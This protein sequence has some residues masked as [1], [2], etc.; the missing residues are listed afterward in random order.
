MRSGTY[1]ETEGLDTL[2]KYADMFGLTDKSGVEIAE[3]APNVST[4]DPMRSAIGQGSNS[5]T[6]AALARYTA[7]I[8]NGGI[9]YNLTLVDKITDSE[10]GVI[11]DFE[12]DVRNVIDLPHVQPG[13]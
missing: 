4:E 10:G 6:T 1:N 9:C 12:P 11:Q 13:H 5:Y 3:A 7:T 2:R 8:A